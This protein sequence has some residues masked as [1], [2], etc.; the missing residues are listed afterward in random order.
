[1]P[2]L[3]FYVK[4]RWDCATGTQ[5]KSACSHAPHFLFFSNFI[6]LSIDL[7]VVITKLSAYIS[8]SKSKRYANITVAYRIPI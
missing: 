6:F 2:L 5:T 1:M 4:Y 3:V 8:S 7:D